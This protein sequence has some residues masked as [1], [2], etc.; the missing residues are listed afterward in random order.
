MPKTIKSKKKTKA[1]DL[2]FAFLLFTFAL[3]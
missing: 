3:I 2:T 1:W